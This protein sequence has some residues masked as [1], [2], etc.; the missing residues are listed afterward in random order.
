MVFSGMRLPKV[1]RIE[2]G[3]PQRLAGLLLVVFAGAV[4]LGGGAAGDFD[5]GLPV[6]AVR[7]GDVGAAFSAGRVLYDLW[8]F[9][10]GWDVCV[11]G[12][13][14]SADAAAAGSAGCRTSCGDR[15]TGLYAEGSLNGST[16][17]A[18]HEIG[19]VKYLLHLPFVFFA[20]WLGGGLWWVSRR[21]FGN[22]GAAGFAGACTAFVRRW[23]GLRWCRITM[24]WRCGGCTGWCIRRLGWL[25]RCMGRVRKWRPR[26]VLC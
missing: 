25:T 12:G 6:C 7:A 21:M 9:E 24:C 22:E 17:E 15:R 13:G 3:R 14:A 4:S 8:E 5:A 1:G 19:S 26:I 10:W 16:W 20:L 11:P 18:R 2:I 23:C